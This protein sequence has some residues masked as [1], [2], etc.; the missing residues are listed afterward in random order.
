MGHQLIL[1]KTAKSASPVQAAWA[2]E[3]S[4]L[5]GKKKDEKRVLGKVNEDVT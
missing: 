2:V 5:R 3:A 1:S 4:M